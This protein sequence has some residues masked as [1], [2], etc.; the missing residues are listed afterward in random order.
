M[1]AAGVARSETI[2]PAG[3]AVLWERLT[4]FAAGTDSALNP[5][6]MVIKATLRPSA[7]VDFVRLVLEIDPAASVQAHAGT[8]VVIVRFAD[9]PAAAISRALIGR[10]QP[11]AAAAA[12]RLVVLSSTHA[13]EL[14]R[15]A[16]W[17]GAMAADTWM[18]KVKQAVRSRKS[19]QP[20]PL[21]ILNEMTDTAKTTPAL[22]PPPASS[23]A[24][25][26]QSGLRHRLS[27]VSRLRSLRLVYLGLPNL[28]RNWQRE[29]QPSRPNLSDAIR[30]R[31]PAAGDAR[32]SP[33]FGAV[34]RLPGVRN[35]L[36]LR[37]AV[38]PSD[39]AVPHCHGAIARRRW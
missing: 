26:G 17:G 25:F 2:A 37:R 12:G 5:S 3:T 32:S 31:R 19:A 15:Q 16:V 38:R 10:L 35:R 36:S 30:D 33:P 20:R 29:R 6:P 28:S 39:R 13:S 27:A 8:G 21:C 22:T 14:T 11:A 24:S 4:Q 18:R 1:A 9:F 34:S 7:V 23:H